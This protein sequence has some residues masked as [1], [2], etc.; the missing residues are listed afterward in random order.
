M[1][2]G[3]SS[4]MSFFLT[5]RRNFGLGKRKSISGFP[6]LQVRR[7]EKKTTKKM[8]KK[9]IDENPRIIRDYPI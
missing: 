9:N 3:H 1:T 6:R 7:L 2:S 5:L 8:F 4:Y